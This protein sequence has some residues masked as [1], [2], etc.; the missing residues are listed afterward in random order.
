VTERRHG[1]RRCYQAERCRCQT[2][3]HANTGY[4]A[5]YRHAQ[6]HGRPVLGTHVPGTEARQLL[7]ELIEEGFLKAEIARWIGH[8]W[9]WLHWHQPE[10]VQPRTVLRLRVIQRRVCS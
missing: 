10:G 6:R 4:M 7:A 3:T 1:T 8:K 5:R 9:P 2:C